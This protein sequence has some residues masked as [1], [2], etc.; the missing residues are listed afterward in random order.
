MFFQVQKKHPNSS[1]KFPV[2]RF[3]LPGRAEL[4]RGTL[5]AHAQHKLRVCG[6]P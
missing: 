6:R 2:A 3:A 5:L 4:R 1:D